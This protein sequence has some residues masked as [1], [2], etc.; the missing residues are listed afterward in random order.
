MV[1]IDGMMKRGEM[2]RDSGILFNGRRDARVMNADH[3]WSGGGMEV[4]EIGRL[5]VDWTTSYAMS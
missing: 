4:E 2:M 1:L 5:L 3:F